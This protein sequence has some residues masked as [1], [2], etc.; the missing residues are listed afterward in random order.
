MAWAIALYWL[1]AGAD[2]M[3]TFI[4][5]VENGGFNEKN[6]VAKWLLSRSDDSALDMTA[7][8]GLK[9]AVFAVFVH[10][11]IHWS[12]LLVAGTAQIAVGIRNYRLLRSKGLFR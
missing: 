1:G 4:G 8:I 10:F 6:P 7:M 3:T 9:A 11:D 12:A 2:I 5:V